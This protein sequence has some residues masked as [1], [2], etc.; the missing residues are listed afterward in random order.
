M[1]TGNM[2]RLPVR[3]LYGSRFRCLLLTHSPRDVV[4]RLLT[5]LIK[6]Y[7]FVDADRDNWMP[8]GL[9]NP[10]EAKLGESDFLSNSDSESVTTWWLEVSQYANTPNW[11]I[12]STCTV[13][14]RPGLVLVEAKAHWGE[15]SDAGKP[16]PTSPNGMKNH[17]RTILATAESN[18]GLN[19]VMSGFSL[20]VESHYQLCN[21]FAWSWK[22]ATLGIPVILVYLGFTN[23]DDMRDRGQTPFNDDSEWERA[24]REAGRGLIPNEAWGA[25]LNIGGTPVIPLIR[26]IDGRWPSD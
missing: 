7:G 4:A 10:T 8:R 5:D 12:V 6:P 25:S 11:D 1:T 23:A 22:I 13:D 18:S 3:D 17:E 2:V 16:V 26:S 9:I 20:T 19:S 14:G 21:R 24:V 15:L